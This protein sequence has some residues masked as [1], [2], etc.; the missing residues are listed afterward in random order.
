LNFLGLT[1]HKKSW[2]FALPISLLFGFLG[3]IAFATPT[4]FTQEETDWLHLNAN[5]KVAVSSDYAPISFMQED[6]EFAGISADYLELIEKQLKSVNP[7]FKFETILPTESER[8]ANDPLDKR[9]DLVVDFVQTPDRLKYW[10]FTKPYLDTPLHLIVRQ[11]SNA[12]NNLNQLGQAQIA[13]V[14]YY[15]AHELL[16]RDYPNLTLILVDSNQEGLKKVAFGEVQGFVSDLPVSSYWANKAGLVQLK[17]AGELSYIYQISFATNKKEKILHNVIEKSLAQISPKTRM[18]IQDRWITG[19]FANKPFFKD[20]RVWLILASLLAVIWLAGRFKNDIY[21]TNNRL[22]KQQ[23]TLALLTQN[24]LRAAQEKHDIFKEYAQAAAQTLDVERVGIWLFDETRQQ[25]DCACLYTKSNHTHSTLPPLLVKDLPIYF[26]EL[27][28]HRVIAVDNA[29]QHPFTQ[30]LTGY[31]KA[32]KVGAM[33]DSTITINGKSVGVV[34]HEHV[35][36][37]REW[38]LDE[39]TF[40][41][42]I[43]DLCRITSETCLRRTAQA[44]LQQY[45][46][47]LAKMVDE[48]SHLLLE[49]EKRYNYVLKHAPIPILILKKSGEIVEVNPEAQAAFGAHRDDMI[50]KNFVKTIV[51][52]ESRKTAVAMA[53]KSLRGEAFRDVELVLQNV[54]GVKLEHVCSI[55]MVSDSDDGEQG[56]MVAIAQNISQQKA[57]QAT[58]IRARE[59]AESADRIKSMFVASMSHELRTP[60]NSIIGF[61]GVVLHGMSGELNVKQK[62]QLGRAYNSSKHLL[63]LITDVIDISKI[64]AGFLQVYVEKFELAT[65]LTEVQHAV[66][67]LAEEKELTLIIDCPPEIKLETDRKRLYQAILNVVSNGLKY[68]EQGT[69]KVRASIKGR[70]LSIM[71]EDEGIGISDAD[72]ANLFKPFVRVDSHLKIKTLGTGLGLYLTRKILS[73]LLGGEITVKSQLGQGSTFTISVPIKMPQLVMQNQTSILEDSFHENRANY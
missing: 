54:S 72:L 52:N 10:Q 40:A 22:I 47:K 17:D 29:M 13:V 5:I 48:R 51:A 2:L 1:L 41:G 12:S 27:A 60:L 45:S 63:S 23:N 35:G 73:Q 8:A 38:T 36:G 16:A 46:D 9:V 37:T 21:K 32:N 53:A 62:D 26:S 65:L 4:K 30:E 55:G 58:L 18:E 11:D 19:P 70:Q 39:Q 69:V 57:L 33:L 43:A 25:L 67:H 49:S 20:G 42:S 28:T 34:C 56:Q 14:G 3:I 68:S 15:A 50:G 61:L 44:E 7:A 64:E 71:V 66:Q 31:L 59:S 6:G 24:Q